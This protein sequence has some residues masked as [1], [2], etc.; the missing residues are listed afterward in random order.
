MRLINQELNSIT[1]DKPG[2]LPELSSLYGHTVALF[3]SGFS[4]A[5]AIFYKKLQLCSKTKRGGK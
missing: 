5:K 1:Q 3:Y 2:Y 4:I